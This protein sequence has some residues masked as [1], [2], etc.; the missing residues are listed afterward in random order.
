MSETKRLGIREDGSLII[1]YAYSDF[2]VY[3]H[4][5]DI[6]SLSGAPS[7]AHWHEDIEFLVVLSGH[8]MVNVNGSAERISTGEGIIINSRQMHHYYADS[9]APCQYLLLLLHPML[10]CV[11]QRASRNW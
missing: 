3:L 11:C 7:D 6:S 2:F 1:D 5:G 9:D 4:K 8:M 10:L